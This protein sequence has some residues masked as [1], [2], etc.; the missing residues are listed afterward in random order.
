[1]ASDSWF[2]HGSPVFS[3]D[4]NEMYFVKMHNLPGGQ[5][6]EIN[7][8]KKVNGQWTEPQVPSFAST[9]YEENNPVLS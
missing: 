6:L 4:G 7:Y 3:P 1:M 9:E 2:W 8:V 5:R